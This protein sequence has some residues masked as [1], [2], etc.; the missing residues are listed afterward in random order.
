M[1][2]VCAAA[3]V[4]GCKSSLLISDKDVESLLEAYAAQN[5]VVEQRKAAAADSGIKTLT[6]M[7]AGGTFNVTADVDRASLDTVIRRLMTQTKSG[8]AMDRPLR[9]T[10]TA[11][12]DN[13]PLQQAVDVLLG[14]QG[15]Q[16]ET[17][18][19]TFVIR[20]GRGKTA[21]QP[22]A[23]PPS[24]TVPPGGA[25]M[26]VPPELVGAHVPLDSL[27]VATAATI[28]NGLY[29]VSSQGGPPPLVAF[30]VHPNINEVYLMGPSE[31]VARTVDILR[32]ADQ[33]PSHV[34]IEALVVEFDR[35]ALDRL[36]VDVINGAYKKVSGVNLDFGALLSEAITF[37]RTGGAH[38]PLAF[39]LLIDLLQAR[40]KARLV[41]RPYV[42]TLSGVQATINITNSRYVLTQGI[43]AGTTTVTPQAVN[44][45]VTLTITPTVTAADRIRIV[46]TVNDSQFVPSSG[47]VAVEVDQ[48][49]AT[50]TML[51]DDGQ[52]MIIG[53]LVLDRS[54]NSNSG[55]PLLRSIPLLNAL[56][57]DQKS[58]RS[59]EEVLIVITP[60]VW[61]PGMNP[62]ITQPGAF[63]IMNR[64]PGNH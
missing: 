44:S 63:S 29:P 48:N 11:R 34:L 40:N 31:A 43:V 15:F 55:V 19:G 64:T 2:A 26:P 39:T 12:F 37:T 62:P 49:Q 54:S 8:Y 58:E 1:A 3:L 51:L 46:A 7:P 27:D 45:G 6:V 21:A 4:S 59:Q 36:G 47:N 60:H 57:A 16:A 9:G 32:D 10:V 42:S 25:T 24:M 28:L 23:A 52:S 33:E 53:G 5:K 14:L 61:T 50:T 20:G 56:F 38:N 18:A 13:L 41:S 35:E 17:Q 30:G 22:V